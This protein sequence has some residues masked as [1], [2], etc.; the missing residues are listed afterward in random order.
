MNLDTGIKTHHKNKLKMDCRP[1]CKPAKL[2]EDDIG[3]NLDD[4]G[5]GDDFLNTAAKTQSM[6]EI[7]GKLDFGKTKN[8]YSAKDTV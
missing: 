5:Y 3:E 2:L 6:K 8:F 1:K 4:L 7:V